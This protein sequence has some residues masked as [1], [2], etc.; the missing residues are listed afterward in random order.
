MRDDWSGGIMKKKSVLAVLFAGVSMSCVAAVLP[1]VGFVYPAGGA[2]GTTLTVTIGGQYLRDFSGI[3]LSGIPVEAKLTDYLK[4]YD[5]QEAGK[6]KRT[7]ET[8]EAQMA[9]ETSDTLKEQMQRQIDLLDQE[10]AMVQEMVREDKMNPA[11]A[12]KKQ[13]NPQIAERVTLEFI[14]PDNAVPGDH[15]LRVITTNGL[16]NPFVFQVGQMPEVSE[17]E[18]NDKVTA[19]EEL[20]ALPVLVNGQIM[21]GDVDCFRFS[22]REGQTLVFRAEARSLVPYLADAVPGWFQAVLTLY[23]EQGNEIAYDDDFRFDPD[24]V[25]I[26]KIQKDGNYILAIRDSIF[27]GREDFVYRVSVGE[28]PFIER[29]FPLGGAEN[30]EVDVKLSGVNLP[31]AGMKLKTGNDAPD[32]KLIRV[33]KGGLTSNTRIFSVSPFAERLEVEPNNLPAQA[34]TVTNVAMF[35]GTI[36]KPGDQDWF[37]FQGFQGEKKTIEISARRLGSPLDARLVLLNSKQEVL[38]SNDDTE[39]K[40]TGLLT[41]H[42]DSR[43]DI[44]LPASGVYFVRL[45]D[46]Q[47]KGGDEYSYRLMIGTEYPDFQLRIIPASL[48]IPRNGT[49]IA[50]VHA[51]RY[52]GFTGEIQLSVLDAP[53]G[54]DLQRAV[55]PAGSDTTRIAIAA[56]AGAEEQ[57]TAL[58]IEGTAEC[59]S[60]IVHRRTIPAE[61]MMQAFIYRHWVSAKQ[62]LVRVSEPEPVTVTLSV[63]KDGVFRA[64]P[65]TSIVINS[66]AK[67]TGNSQ[68]SIKLTLAQPPEW[69]TLKTGNIGG[70]GGNITLAVSPN[71]EPGDKATVLLNGNIRLEKLPTDPDYNPVPKMKFMNA[72]PI[73]FTIDAISIEI[74]N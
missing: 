55:I 71:A 31:S 45:D 4:I 70:Q 38:A 69:L 26:Y 3:H 37:R 24:P 10:M 73:D 68:K 66:S 22:A 12:A 65:G 42:A 35:N 1:H 57:I 64:R 48:C 23:D 36:G 49:A 52:G 13:F 21:P 50:T 6:V 28:T 33:E 30:S 40:G 41:H 17:N 16:S 56:K 63:P 51:I 43:I 62:L 67:W 7:K 29:I 39:D 47:G 15:E 8:I 44:T 11:L 18:P 20:P 74:T 54:L 59:N 27:R 14:L 53:S 60:R 46:L 58:E 32:T 25:L 61:D 5:R 9:E 19:A 34:Q 72:K 2:P